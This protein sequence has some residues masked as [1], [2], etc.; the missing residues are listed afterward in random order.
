MTVAEIEANTNYMVPVRKEE[1]QCLVAAGLGKG[2]AE[3]GPPELSLEVG[4]VFVW[5]ANRGQDV[6]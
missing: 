5:Q 3:K 6:H 4:A 1:K 2:I